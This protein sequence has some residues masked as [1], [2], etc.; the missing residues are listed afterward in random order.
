MYTRCIPDIYPTYPTYPTHR[1]LRVNTLH[2]RLRVFTHARTSYKA[3]VY[4]SR[5]SNVYISSVRPRDSCAR[6]LFTPK[7]LG[8]P[9]FGDAQHPPLAV[10]RLPRRRP[11]AEGAGGRGGR[12]GGGVTPYIPTTRVRAARLT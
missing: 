7:V 3:R 4:I 1:R 9:A 6:Q 10:T 5:S 12:H 8:Y 2:R 11:R